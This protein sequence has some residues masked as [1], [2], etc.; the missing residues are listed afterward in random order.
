MGICYSQQITEP[1]NEP[2]DQYNQNVVF[3]KLSQVKYNEKTGQPIV[4]GEQTFAADPELL[5]AL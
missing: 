3:L 5:A 2:V 1:K 4:D